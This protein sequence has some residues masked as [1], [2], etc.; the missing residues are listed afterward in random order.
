MQMDIVTMKDLDISRIGA[1]IYTRRC[2][3]LKRVK[4]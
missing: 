2:K 4:V 3:G 1:L